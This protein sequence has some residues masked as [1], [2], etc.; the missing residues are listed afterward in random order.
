M[1]NAKTTPKM[2]PKTNPRPVPAAAFLVTFAALTL[3][4]GCAKTEKTA[5][6]PLT[7]HQRDSVLATEPIPGAPAVGAALR[8]SERE[9]KRA[10]GMDTLGR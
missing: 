5:K 2:N 1:M 10:A 4:A 9:S 6:A 3:L 7:E 8:A